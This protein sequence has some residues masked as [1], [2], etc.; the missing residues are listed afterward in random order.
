M[1]HIDNNQ[2]VYFYTKLFAKQG[3][4]LYN[5]NLLV[6][7]KNACWILVNEVI[8]S[9]KLISYKEKSHDRF[10]LVFEFLAHIV[11][12]EI[13]IMLTFLIEYFGERVT[14]VSIKNFV[15]SITPISLGELLRF[16]DT[17]NFQDL[18]SIRLSSSSNWMVFRA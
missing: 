8:I 5:F 15:L 9:Y 4:H 3:C 1:I 18:N 13:E 14:V 16:V 11:T 17:P 10:T 2:Q 7:N 6:A 12:H